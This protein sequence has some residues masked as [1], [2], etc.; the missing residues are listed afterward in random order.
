MKLSDVRKVPIDHCLD[1]G[2]VVDRAT[3]VGEDVA[4]EPNAITI[5][6]RCGHVMAFAEDLSLRQ[7]TDQ[8]I[9]MVAGDRRLIAFQRAR[10]MVQRPKS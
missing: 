6:I 2:T 9:I 7:L 5:C 3:C 8:E 4:P 1:C 10:K